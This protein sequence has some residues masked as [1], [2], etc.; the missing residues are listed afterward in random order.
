LNKKILVKFE[1]D[2]GRCGEIESLF[3]ATKKDLQKLDG[4]M[5][6]FNEVLGKHSFVEHLCKES[7]FKIVSNDEDKINWLVSI[8]GEQISGITLI[9][10]L[11]EPIL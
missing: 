3:V 7:D 10:H 2:C 1:L 11:A 9:E 4:K 5:L 6:H 8:L